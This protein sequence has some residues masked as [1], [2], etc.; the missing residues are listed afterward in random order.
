MSLR[1]PRLLLL[2]SGSWGRSAQGFWSLALRPSGPGSRALSAQEKALCCGRHPRLAPP[3][4]GEGPVRDARR[5]RKR[6]GRRE[7][8]EQGAGG[9][10]CRLHRH[11]W[12]PGEPD[13][14][15]RME[16]ALGAVAA[17]GA[18]ATRY[19][20]GPSG[21][22]VG[23]SGL[24]RSGGRGT[25]AAGDAPN[26]GPVSPGN[27]RRRGWGGGT[28]ECWVL[29]GTGWAG[30]RGHPRSPQPSSTPS[31]EGSKLGMSLARRAPFLLW[32]ALGC[33]LRVHHLTAC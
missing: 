28:A 30:S 18:P 24:H 15:S 27:V 26:S 33:L 25:G 2:S 6:L 32:N 13:S 4:H 29:G 11:P 8:E 12:V 19:R 22:G 3:G 16:L 21:P 17:P 23:G 31:G 9:E 20:P 5:R 1:P 10:G 14:G 7:A